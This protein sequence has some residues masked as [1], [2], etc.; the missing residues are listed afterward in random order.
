MRNDLA[1]T[2]RVPQ[3]DVHFFNLNIFL[4]LIS[5]FVGCMDAFS[6]KKDQISKGMVGFS[7]CESARH[8]KCSIRAGEFQGQ[9][10]YDDPHTGDNTLPGDHWYSGRV[11]QCGLNIA[12]S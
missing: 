11:C 7:L 4:F 6:I 12:L 9:E 5:L 2:E 8:I 3:K 1:K 10:Q